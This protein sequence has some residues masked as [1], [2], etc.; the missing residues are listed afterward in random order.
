MTGAPRRAQRWSRRHAWVALV[1]APTWGCAGVRQV[2]APPGAVVLLGDDWFSHRARELGSSV[3]DAR[4]RDAALP[5]DA[6]P[7]GSDDPRLLA[8]AS[9]LWA[10]LCAGCHGVDGEPP[11][12]PSGVLD[13]R[14]VATSS[15]SA[16]A[17]RRP[18]TWGGFGVR[19]GFLFGG[20]GMRA[21]LYR[22]IAGG[23]EPVVGPDGARSAP[24]MPAWRESLAR[25]QIWALVRHLEGF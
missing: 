1:L 11:E 23:G 6:P 22:R 13:G 21:G 7:E 25:E 4:A 12:V 3:E 9:V 10:N 20:D 17:T 15:S 8:H 18:R 5:E 2:P 14:E 24:V 16:A 19:M